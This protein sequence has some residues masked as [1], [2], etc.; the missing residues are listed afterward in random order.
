MIGIYNIVAAAGGLMVAFCM[1]KYCIM[2]AQYVLYGNI[3]K[4]AYSVYGK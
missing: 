3:D 4:R 1:G 2:G